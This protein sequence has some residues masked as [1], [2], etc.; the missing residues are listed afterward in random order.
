MVR[1]YLHADES[2][3]PGR[4]LQ[5]Q[6]LERE[7]ATAESLARL[8]WWQRPVFRWTVKQAQDRLIMRE[9]TKELFVRAIDRGRR[10]SR[11]IGQRL[12]DQPSIIWDLLSDVARDEVAAVDR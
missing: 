12:A 9:H 7:Q 11:H 5:R 6:R 2:L 8:R 4:M 1:N 10:L 3:E